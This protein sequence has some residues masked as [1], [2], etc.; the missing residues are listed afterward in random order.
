MSDLLTLSQRLKTVVKDQ[1]D[2][3]YG[4]LLRCDVPST[5]RTAKLRVTM[6][7]GP[8]LPEAT[9]SSLSRRERKPAQPGRRPTKPVECWSIRQGR[10]CVLDGQ[11][12][13][14]RSNLKMR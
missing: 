6:Y 8:Q 11:L 7:R 14:S 13:T 1:D 5:E 12:G 10:L 9:P 3:F 4:L 2:R